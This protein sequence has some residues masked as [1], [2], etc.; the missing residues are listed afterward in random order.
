MRLWHKDLIQYL[1][2]QQLL[3]QWRECCCI[4]K[5]ITKRGSPH[6]LLVNKVMLY[7]SVHFLEYTRLVIREMESRGYGVSEKSK[8]N[9][10]K[11]FSRF[12]DPCECLIGADRFMFDNWHD[13][14]YLIQCLYNLQ[15]KEDCGGI[16]SDEWDKIQNKFGKYLNG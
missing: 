15:E 12:G 7:P 13:D 6:H 11:N 14:R 10:L 16:P 3:S 1:P 5:T 2:R 8:E 4:A 9:F